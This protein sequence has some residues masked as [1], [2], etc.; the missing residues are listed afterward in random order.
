MYKASTFNVSMV[1]RNVQ[2]QHFILATVL[3]CQTYTNFIYSV[4][5]NE[6]AQPPGMAPST[7]PQISLY[8]E[9]I[10][11]ETLLNNESSIPIICGTLQNRRKIM[12]TFGGGGCFTGVSSRY[13]NHLCFLTFTIKHYSCFQIPPSARNN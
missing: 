4:L 5:K 3:W 12:N 2:C 9:E 11:K 7:I 13:R 1:C 10:P 6:T 8:F